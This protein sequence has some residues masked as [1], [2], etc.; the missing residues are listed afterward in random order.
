MPLATSNPMLPVVP[1]AASMNA[2]GPSMSPPLMVPAPMQPGQEGIDSVDNISQQPQNPGQQEQQSSLP[3]TTQPPTLL[4]EIA[5][6]NI[7]FRLL[8][9]FSF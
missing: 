6:V 3:Q 4:P 9:L 1:G 5:Q 2:G 8:P 7:F